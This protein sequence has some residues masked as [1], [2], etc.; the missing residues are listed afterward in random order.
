MNHVQTM[1][2]INLSVPCTDKYVQCTYNLQACM[3]KLLRTDNL[4]TVYTQ[5]TDTG[6][7]R[8]TK[9]TH[10]Q[11]FKMMNMSVPCTDKFVQCT[12][13]VHTLNVQVQVFMC[14][15]QKVAGV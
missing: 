12:Y 2:R 11:T 3:Y 10:V 14:I 15:E 8:C 1:N 4:Q 13:N 7:P 9:V 5:C 6:E